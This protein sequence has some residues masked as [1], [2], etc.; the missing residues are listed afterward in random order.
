MTLSQP[1]ILRPP[2]VRGLTFLTRRTRRRLHKRDTHD[3][4]RRNLGVAGRDNKQMNK[5][6]KILTV[7]A[8]AVF[9]VIIQLRG[10]FLFSI[11]HRWRFFH[12][13][14]TSC[15]LSGGLAGTRTRDQ[16]LKR[17]LLYRLSR[18]VKYWEIIARNLKRRGWNLGYVSAI[19]SNGRTNRT[20][21][22]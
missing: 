6:R 3:D 5:K 10:A 22:L 2:N 7:V 11:D 13:Q 19:D 15:I 18:R 16:R 4:G 20:K 14:P 17:P 21:V 8:L 12:E 9:G 1:S